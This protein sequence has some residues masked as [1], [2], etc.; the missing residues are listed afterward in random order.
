[1]VRITYNLHQLRFTVGHCLVV[2]HKKIVHQIHKH[3]C[4]VVTE[5]LEL[6]AGGVVRQTGTTLLVVMAVVVA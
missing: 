6:G 4:S 5:A 3:G 2:A 1:V